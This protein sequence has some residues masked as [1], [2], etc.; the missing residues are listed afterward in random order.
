M[1]LNWF[2]VFFPKS[3]S[4]EAAGDGVNDNI[5]WNIH[6]WLVVSTHLKNMIVKLE[7]FPK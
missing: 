6:N 1:G 5:L 3:S 2:N 4:A 7:I